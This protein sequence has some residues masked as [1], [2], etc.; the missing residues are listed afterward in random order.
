MI[1]ETIGRGLDQHKKTYGTGG[2][3]SIFQGNSPLE[4]FA[5]SWRF[6]DP[7]LLRKM[8][9]LKV[10]RKEDMLRQQK[11]TLD[12]LLGTCFPRML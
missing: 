11:K 1:E 8:T 2:L 6:Q 12:L 10:G 3:L 7:K 5:Q 4:I 9:R